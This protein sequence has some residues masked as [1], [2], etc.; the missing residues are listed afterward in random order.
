MDTKKLKKGQ[1]YKNYKELCNE[2][3]EKVKTGVSKQTQIN[4][5]ESYFKFH[6]EG[7]SIVIDEVYKKPKGKMSRYGFINDIEELILDLLVQDDHNGNLYLSKNNLFFLL[8]LVNENYNF[9]R[10][11]IPKL[12]KMMQIDEQ[13]IYEFFNFSKDSMVRSIENALKNLSKKS[14][15]FWTNSITVC[16]IEAETKVNNNGIKIEEKITGKNEYGDFIYEYEILGNAYKKHKEATKE[17]I[18]IILKAE[19]KIMNDLNCISKQEVVKKGLWSDFTKKVKEIIF[20]SA[21]IIYYYESYKI[22]TN[23]EYIYELW[24]D[25][26]DLELSDITR[27][28]KFKNLNVYNKQKLLNNAIKRYDKEKNKKE[29]QKTNEARKNK[30]YIDNNQKLLEG[31]IDLRTLSFKTELNSVKINDK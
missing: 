2:L 23:K 25:L 18:E 22:I 7:Y 28:Q 20:D 13:E 11:H 15:I 14:L 16:K 29:G 4:Y 9:S 8:K 31:L 26:K 17:E 19:R 12:S 24:E 30:L 5:W 10:Y 1:I 27:D 6:K 21:N 3:G